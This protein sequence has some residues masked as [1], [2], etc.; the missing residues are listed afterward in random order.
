MAK[1]AQH[2][3]VQAQAREDLRLAMQ[4]YAKRR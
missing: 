4:Y 3:V 1:N 2:L